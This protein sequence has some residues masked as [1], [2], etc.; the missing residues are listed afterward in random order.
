MKNYREADGEI[1]SLPGGGFTENGNAH[2]RST[3]LVA[4]IAPAH[5]NP[6]IIVTPTLLGEENHRAKCAA[7]VLLPSPRPGGSL[8]RSSGPARN[9]GQATDF[10]TRLAGSCVKTRT[11]P[12]AR[13]PQPPHYS[14]H[15]KPQTASGT[16]HNLGCGKFRISAYC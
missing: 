12:L 9:A 4:G 2:P 16:V 13:A 5:G 7:V 3:G 11:P 14:V 8:R 1:I 10:H 15:N 6:P